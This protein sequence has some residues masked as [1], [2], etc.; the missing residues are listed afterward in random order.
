LEQQRGDMTKTFL[1][2]NNP[3]ATAV[4]EPDIE[5]LAWVKK[6]QTLPGGIETRKGNTSIVTPKLE[7][8]ENLKYVD[9]NMQVENIGSEIPKETNSSQ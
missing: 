9:A 4:V 1:Q 8:Q 2:L 7:M 5:T 6:I 3:L